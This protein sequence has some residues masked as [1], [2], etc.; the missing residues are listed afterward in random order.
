MKYLFLLLIFV[1]NTAPAQVNPGSRFRSL[2][3]A[4]VA[5]QDVWSLQHN[6]AGLAGLKNPTAAIGYE[7]RYLDQDV[8]T[9]S[10]LF[11]YPSKN[12][13]FGISFQRYG[14]SA[15]N[16]QQVSFALARSFGNSI[17]AALDF[18]FHQVNIPNY[19]SAQ[20]FSVEAGL[21]YRATDNLWLGAH[22]A[23]PT[24]NGYNTSVDAVVPVS[25]QFG[26]SYRF[27]DKVL[28]A[29]SIEKTLN[30][31]TDLRTGLEYNII[32]WL[33]LRGGISA[34]P[35]GQYVGFGL[36]HQHFRIDVAASSHP[37]L[38]YSPQ[39]AIGYGF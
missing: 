8:S 26:A 37:V 38:G 17:Y 15:Y 36:N 32:S 25:L 31:N 23:N 14:F 24:R 9:Q 20:T 12:N 19:G 4:G 6:Q 10:A 28:I 18:N 30:E 2:A 33:A 34:N 11:A 7:Q 22:V 27:S 3:S 5:L 29:S 35:F 16:E 21:Q 39:I 13:V 1:Y